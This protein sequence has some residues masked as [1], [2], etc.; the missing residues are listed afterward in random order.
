M[1]LGRSEHPELDVAVDL[2]ENVLADGRP[3]A[4]GIRGDDPL[5]ADGDP[6]IVKP[7]ATAGLHVLAHWSGS[8]Q[9]NPSPSRAAA[10]SPAAQSAPIQARGRLA[11]GTGPT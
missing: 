3:C 10:R 1:S 5:V 8:T 6:A 4:L 9:T 2:I 7:E 11:D